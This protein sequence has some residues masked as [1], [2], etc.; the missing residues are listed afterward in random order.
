MPILQSTV[1]KTVS[2]EKRGVA[3]S[4]GMIGADVGLMVGNMAMGVAVSANGN[5][6]RMGYMVMA[7]IAIVALVFIVCYFHFY[8]KK[9]EGNPLGW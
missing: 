3:A 2:E 4:T 8:N 9:R 7:P 6:Y 1:I 5:S